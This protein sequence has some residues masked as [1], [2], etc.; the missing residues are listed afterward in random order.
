MIAVVPAA[1]LYA[2]FVAPFPSTTHTDPP[3]QFPVSLVKNLSSDA[4]IFSEPVVLDDTLS[5]ISTPVRS[6]PYC[7]F[8]AI[9]PPSPLFGNTTKLPDT[10]AVAAP[11]PLTF[12]TAKSA[13]VV[14]VP[15]MRRSRVVANF[16]WIVP[17]VTFQL[18]PLVE[19]SPQTAAA[20]VPPDRRQ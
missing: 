17:W 1:T 13:D 15:P 10:V 11:D 3:V 2:L 5:F 6:A 9:P 4:V 16:G 18:E 7:L 8:T 19:Q 20:A 14:A 12:N